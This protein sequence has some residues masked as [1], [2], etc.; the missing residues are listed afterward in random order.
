MSRGVKCAIH[1]EFTVAPTKSIQC[2]LT[3]L[4][5]TEPQ[6][7][8]SFRT[9]LDSLHCR[10]A[11][12]KSYQ[13]HT[14]LLI[15]HSP[16]PHHIWPS[17]LSGEQTETSTSPRACPRLPI[18]PYILHQIKSTLSNSFN[19]IMIWAATCTVFFGFLRVGAIPL[20]RRFWASASSFVSTSL[21]SPLSGTL[22]V[23]MEWLNPAWEP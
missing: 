22:G 2:I 16:L 17:K 15:W 8:S 18:T 9:H 21:A 12:V 11:P 5:P 19:D 14:Y 20:T 23:S 7:A 13:H 3:I 1:S 4:S 6:S 10:A